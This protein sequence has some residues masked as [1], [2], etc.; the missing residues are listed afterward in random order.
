MWP[1]NED[2]VVRT[3][4][5]TS[6]SAL[7]TFREQ[8]KICLLQ[9]YGY[10]PYS[11]NSVNCLRITK[12]L[13]LEFTMSGSHLYHIRE[14]KQQQRWQLRKH[15]KVNSRC[16]KLYHT[17]SIL[18]NSSNV[19]KFFWELN[20]ERLYQ[21]SGKEKESCCLGFLSMTKCEIKHFH[22]V[23]LQRHLRK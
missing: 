17:Y 20:S 10:K 1:T 7:V 14:F 8:Q 12:W 3:Y 21:S 2:L 16:L 15:Q 11:N 4:G 9:C 19:G 5:W 22:V 13:Q 18:F 23:V 6:T